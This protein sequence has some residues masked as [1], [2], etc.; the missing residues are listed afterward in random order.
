MW[1]NW[2]YFETPDA[3]LLCLDAKDGH[4]RWDVELAT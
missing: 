2:L 3:H 4:V 1:G